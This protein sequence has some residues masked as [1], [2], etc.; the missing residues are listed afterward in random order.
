MGPTFDADTVSEVVG[1]AGT[2][3]EQLRILADNGI[4]EPVDPDANI[5]RFRHALLRD[6]AYETQVLDVRSQTHARVAETIADR[7]AEPALIAEHFDLATR[8]VPRAS[9]SS[10][11]RPNRSR[12]APEATRL[13]FPARSSYSRA[14]QNPMTATS[15]S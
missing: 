15:T 3:A 5:Y 12:S 1:A 14:S 10:P 13:F 2:V 6:A 4:I 8:S 9:I 11:R 7:G